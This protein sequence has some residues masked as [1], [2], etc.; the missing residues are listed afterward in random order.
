[1]DRR[2]F[3]LTA[4]TK[5]PIAMVGRQITLTLAE[6]VA[7][8]PDPY[9]GGRARA[10]ASARSDL[11]RLACTPVRHCRYAVYPKP[12]FMGRRRSRRF[13]GHKAPGWDRERSSPN[14]KKTFCPGQTTKLSAARQRSPPLFEIQANHLGGLGRHAKFS[15]PLEKLSVRCLG[16]LTQSVTIAIRQRAILRTQKKP[17]RGP[18]RMLSDLL[19]ILPLSSRV[20]FCVSPIC[21]TSR[22]IASAAMKRSFGAKFAKSC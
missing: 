11:G 10:Y 12:A 4:G 2:Q 8:N 22:S 16:E 1:M 18:S 21:L 7:R 20:A 3:L 13:A 17:C 15:Q 14:V 9:Q 19:S 6:V 5:S